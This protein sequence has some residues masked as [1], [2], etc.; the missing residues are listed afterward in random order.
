[1]LNM[2]NPYVGNLLGLARVD[3]EMSA[4]FLAKLLYMDDGIDTDIDG[5]LAGISLERRSS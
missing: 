5:S 4:Y 3:P 2:D 1:M